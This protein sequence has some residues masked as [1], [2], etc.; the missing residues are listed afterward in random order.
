M[1][2]N[3]LS[4]RKYTLEYLEVKDP[5]IC[6]ISSIG[7]QKRCVCVWGGGYRNETSDKANRIKC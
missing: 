4:L 2:K 3:I 6:N 7:L 1:E 5:D